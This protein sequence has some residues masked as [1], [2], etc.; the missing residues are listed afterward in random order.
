MDVKGDECCPIVIA[1]RC[2][3]APNRLVNIADIQP[4]LSEFDK[5]DDSERGLHRG[6]VR[7]GLF[8]V[9]VENLEVLLLHSADRVAVL[10]DNNDIEVD[11]VHI[12]RMA[13]APGGP[14]WLDAGAGVTGTL[15][16]RSRLV[17]ERAQ[18]L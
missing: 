3:K 14:D 2:N 15:L 6:E 17:P 1:E 16:P 12:E 8:D 9:V 18:K 5:H 4:E 13:P 10:V 7:D 11:Q